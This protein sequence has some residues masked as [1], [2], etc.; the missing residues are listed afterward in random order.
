MSALSQ[1]LRGVAGPGVRRWD[2]A[3]PAEAAAAAARRQGLRV[4]LLQ[5][6]RIAGEDDV[7]DTLAR[8][9]GLPAHYGRNLDALADVLRDVPPAVVL[10]DDAGAGGLD[11]A[12]RA[13]LQRVL[14][15][16]LPVLVRG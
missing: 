8:A 7:H 12:R 10:W 9:L 6:R 4:V 11:P 13:L 16:R 2:S 3:W 15:E 14:G 5:G 1:V